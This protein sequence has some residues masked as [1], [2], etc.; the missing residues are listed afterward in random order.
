[1]AGDAETDTAFDISIYAYQGDIS[2]FPTQLADGTHLAA[3][4]NVLYSDSNPATWQML[5]A[6]LLLPTNT[7]FITIGLI[8]NENIFN[9]V[10]YPEFDGHFADGISAEIVPEPLSALLLGIGAIV[11]HN[12]QRQYRRYQ[13][14]S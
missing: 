12:K 14:K 7:D 3:G 4:S 6:Q 11:L 13:K 2:S 9:D 5:E 1:V 10:S 8:A